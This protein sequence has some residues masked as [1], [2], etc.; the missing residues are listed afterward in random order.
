MISDTVSSLS[1]LIAVAIALL[2]ILVYLFA[3]SK[4]PHFPLINGKRLFEISD[5]SSKK[6]YL[7]DGHGLIKRGLQKV[8]LFV[9]RLPAPVE[10][11]QMTRLQCFALYPTTDQR[12][13]WHQSML[14]KFAAIL[15]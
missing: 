2:P 7:T 1:P 14:L 15:G 13:F 8:S 9:P 11:N 5:A 6:R 4:S 3:I 12:L 10:I